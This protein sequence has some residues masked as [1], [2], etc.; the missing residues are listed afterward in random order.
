M[1]V[2]V[3]SELC[4]HRGASNI[5]QIN[6]HALHNV[7]L[8]W[9]FASGVHRQDSIL[10]TISASTRLKMFLLLVYL[11][12]LRL[13]LQNI[14]CAQ[15]THSHPFLPCSWASVSTQ[16]LLSIGIDKS[17]GWIISMWVSIESSFS[18]KKWQCCRLNLYRGR[19]RKIVGDSLDY[20]S[21]EELELAR[22][23][24]LAW[25]LEETLRMW[26]ERLEYHVGAG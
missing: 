14:S 17:S 13:P 3:F 8:W 24:F 20:R 15:P 26:N 2:L 11:L 6:W 16:E 1:S 18:Q 12:V 7:L 19:Q 5:W 9:N 21:W 10:I 22:L 25:F 4:C 23:K